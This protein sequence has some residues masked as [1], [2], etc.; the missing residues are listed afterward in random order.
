MTFLKLWVLVGGTGRNIG[1][2]TLM[3]MLIANLSRFGSVTGIKISNIKPEGLEFHGKH[4]TKSD[5][6]FF[7][8]E[9]TRTD[10]NKDSMRFLK[11]G[12]RKSFFIR[13]NDNFLPA[14]F[15]EMQSHLNGNEIVVCESNSLINIMKPAVF[16]MIKG[17]SNR[18][19]KAYVEA[20]LQRADYILNALDLSQFNRVADACIL[21]NGQVQLSITEDINL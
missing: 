17:E 12:A 18:A 5:A 20:S 4:E 19:F 3:E 9:E 2:T 16:L 10:G 14:A 21:Q 6:G 8:W 1:K 15:Q 13:T 7:I 11:A